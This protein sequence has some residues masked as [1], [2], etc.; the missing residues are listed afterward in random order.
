M[1]AAQTPHTDHRKRLLMAP[2]TEQELEE[3]R[4]LADECQAQAQALRLA[5]RA[6]AELELRRRRR[7]R[8]VEAAAG[9][10]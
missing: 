1:S 7:L 3:L 8:E 10:E 4:Q 2:P 5:T 6:R 9:R